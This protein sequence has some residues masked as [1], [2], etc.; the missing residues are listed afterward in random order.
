M[1]CTKWQQWPANKVQIILSQPLTCDRWVKGTFITVWRPTSAA[2][3]FCV[4]LSCGV[5]GQP[6]WQDD[7][8]LPL[9]LLARPGRVKHS[10][11][12]CLYGAC[13]ATFGR[14]SPP[15]ASCGALQVSS[16]NP[17]G[18]QHVSDSSDTAGVS[19]KLWLKSL[20]WFCNAVQALAA[21]GHS[22]LCC[23]SCSCVREGSNQTS[24]RLWRTCG[25][26]E[27]AWS[28]LWWALTD[29]EM[30]LT[31]FRNYLSGCE[32]MC[33]TNAHF[34]RVSAGF[35]KSNLRLFKTTMNTF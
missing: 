32:G 3:D 30:C 7:Y 27:C 20:L 25:C 23:G 26:I 17:L 33:G 2:A 35:N 8:S 1:G 22:W 24:E 5:A 11:S 28:R 14:H 19:L 10:L 18:Y 15:G 16:L 9:P 29:V 4:H 34:N 6:S 31:C 21:R 12:L 13:A